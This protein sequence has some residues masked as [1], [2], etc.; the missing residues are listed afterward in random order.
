LSLLAYCVK[1]NSYTKICLD[2]YAPP[3]LDS[4]SLHLEFP[5]AFDLLLCLAAILL[6]TSPITL[7]KLLKLID[8]AIDWIERKQ[9]ER[10]VDRADE[11][12]R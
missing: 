2:N 1:T 6:V 7:R 11:A 9:F 4:L 8:L 5:L 12:G 10:L 3:V